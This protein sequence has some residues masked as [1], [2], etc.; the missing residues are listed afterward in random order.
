MSVKL[1]NSANILLD[2]EIK[3]KN[4]NQKKSK[5]AQH[6]SKNMKIDGFRKGKIPLSVIESRFKEKINQDSENQALQEL[7]EES[8]KELNIEATQIIG[9]PIIT[10][11]DRTDSGIK[12]EA[13]IGVFPKIEIKDYE[14]SIPEAILKDVT[15]KEIDDKLKELSKAHGELIEVLEEKVLDYGDIANIDFE[16]FLNDKAFDGGKSKEYDLEIGSKSFI[17]GFEEQ[18]VGMKKEEKKDIKVTFPTNYNSK[19]LAGKEAIFKVKLNKIKTRKAIEI[20]DDLAKKILSNNKDA[21]IETLKN[22]TKKELQNETKNKI[23]NELKPQLVENLL[24]DIDFDLPDSIVEQEIDLL[25]RNNL[26]NI[27]KEEL[28]DLQN[29]A[30]KAKDKRESYKNEA[31]KSVK[32]TFIVDYLAK[33]DNIAVN[34]NEVYQLLYYE[35]MMMGA[36]LEEIIKTYE[37]NNMIP[38]LKM[39]ILE[40]KVLNALL[41]SKIKQQPAQ[42]KQNN[43]RDKEEK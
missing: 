39:T 40:N 30:E 23:L 2:D 35:A 17:A 21:T 13:K 36:N 7:I 3:D 42:E 41:E 15:D 20:N 14:K 27:S 38:A 29:D 28:K 10:K 33:K 32:L 31:R 8:L 1:I 26:Q 37:K 12:V 9:S 5:I 6:L 24:N 19:D 16:G 4:I 25:F 22:E 43:N 34:D 11:Y 18:L